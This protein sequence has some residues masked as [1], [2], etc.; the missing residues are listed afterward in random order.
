MKVTLPADL[1]LDAEI[2]LGTNLGAYG[3]AARLYVSLPGLDLKA[4][5]TLVDAAHQTCPFSKA[6]R[7]N[8]DVT[9]NLL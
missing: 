8:V 1:V 6:T 5:Q 7:G 3:L 9:I 2:D 4:A